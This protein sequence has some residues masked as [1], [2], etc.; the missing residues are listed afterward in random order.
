M[1]TAEDFAR[2]D[3]Y[4]DISDAKKQGRDLGIE[5]GRKQGIEK[6]IEEGIKEG[7]KEGRKEGIKL[8]IE[9]GRA[10]ER[11]RADELQKELDELKA[12]YG[13]L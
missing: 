1:L 13:V 7:R 5:E 2:M 4:T 8:G 3:Y 12:K 6:G 9:R 10:M 11:K